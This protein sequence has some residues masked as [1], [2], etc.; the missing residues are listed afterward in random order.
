MISKFGRILMLATLL[1]AAFSGT[2]A[3]Q[4]KSQT[5]YAGPRIWVG[6]LN[7]A[8]AIGGQIERGFTEPGDY[9]PGIVSGGV[10][11]DW[12]SWSYDYPAFGSYDYTVVPVQ[13]FGNYHFVLPNSPKVDPYVG[14]ALVYS[15]VSAKWSG[16]GAQSFSASGSGTDFAGQG[17][18]RYFISETFAVQA[19]VGFGYG[20]LGLGASWAF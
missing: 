13:V 8:V 5:N 1:G 12:Y 14:L 17:G 3:A 18:V 15:H 16:A 10:G 20:S 6:N 2:A 4:F 19:Q 7:G 11:L 9:G